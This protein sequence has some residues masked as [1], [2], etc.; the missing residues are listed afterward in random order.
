MKIPITILAIFLSLSSLLCAANASGAATPIALPSLET[1][2]LRCQGIDAK[3]TKIP[4]SLA[5][6]KCYPLERGL[7][8]KP[9]RGASVQLNAPAEVYLA[10]MQRGTP[11]IDSSW[12]KTHLRL[13]WSVAGKSF[14]DVLYKKAAPAG[15][16]EVPEHNGK[17]KKQYGLPHLLMVPPSVQ[18]AAVSSEN[19]K[20]APQE[21]GTR[22]VA[23]TPD[24]KA[25]PSV[26]F[27]NIDD[28]N[29]WNG[30]LKGHPQ[31]ITPNLDRFAEKSLSFT[32]A[33]CPS[34]MCFPSRTAIF[35]GL[36]PSST[37]A[38]SNSNSKRG[39]RNYVP[40]AVILPKLFSDNGW[41]SVGIGKNLHG[42]ASDDFDESFGS[43]GRKPKALP[44]TGFYLNA[45]GTWGVAD[46]PKTKMPDYNVVSMGIESLKSK[47]D[48][49]FLALGIYRPHV[50]WIVPQEYF[51]K[52]PLDTLV[53]PETIENDLD[54]LSERFKLM[55]HNEAK[56]G[57]D[58]HKNAVAKGHD[59]DM[60]RAYLACVTFADEQVGRI[61]DAWYASSHAENGYV[62]L[63]SDHGFQLSEKEGWS[64]MKP[65][66]DSAHVNLMIAGPDL[67]KGEFCHRAVSLM[68]L[69]PTLVELLNL[70]TPPQGLDGKSLMPLLKN[71]QAQWDQPVLMSSEIDGVRYDVV[72]DN[73]YRMTRLTTGETELYKLASDPHEFN[74]LADNPEYRPVIAKLSEHLSFSFPTLEQDGWVEAEAFPHQT[75]SDFKQRG[76]YHY[77]EVHASASQGKVVCADLRKGVGAYLEFVVSI[78]APGD[79]EL[80][81]AVLAQGDCSLLTAPVV[82]DAKQAAI[83]Y[84]MKKL[85]DI[86]KSSGEAINTLSAGT[87]TFEQSGLHLLRFSSKVEKQLLRVDRIQIRKLN[88]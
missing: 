45:S 51:D 61:L 9:G 24:G 64:K 46:V 36:H 40:E 76:N 85:L 17:T 14:S 86:P 69:Y 80:A 75:S 67:P 78:D 29:D 27:L 37:G 77:P 23:K 20:G 53:M 73:D 25:R 50:P 83:G 79:Y 32:R 18:V 47:D 33:I 60:V 52:Y 2:G 6:F 56:F 70:P 12:E 87:V 66:F 84:P 59:K 71:P 88:H 35:S 1:G 62:V 26:L 65:W 8:T 16:L 57:P 68:D 41:W 13:E 81:V 28:W 11:S 21:T 72:M 4:E 30:V 34:P 7:G 58:Y 63:W 38:K 15:R 44:G 42:R 5:G 31:A 43:G 39:W 19:V 10:V 55:A 54:D 49:L 74:N 22:T 3:I 48:G 82:D